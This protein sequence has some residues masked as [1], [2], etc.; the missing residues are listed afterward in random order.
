MIAAF[1]KPWKD[2]KPPVNTTGDVANITVDIAYERGFNGNALCVE[3][4]KL[5]TLEREIEN[6]ANDRQVES[7][8]NPEE[9]NSLQP[10]CLGSS[11]DIFGYFSKK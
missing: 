5:S 11:I 10:E 9:P 2:A 3:G 7:M 6:G 1:D 4:K 8:G